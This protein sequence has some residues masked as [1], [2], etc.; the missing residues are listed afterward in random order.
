MVPSENEFDAP[1]IVVDSQ[2][3]EISKSRKILVKMK[4][5]SFIFTE[6]K[7]GLFGQPSAYKQTQRGS[8]N[9]ETTEHTSNERTGEFSRKRTKSNA[10]T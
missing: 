2:Q 9:G 5:V 6:K 4:N 10:G 8:E 1:A 3:I 7:Y